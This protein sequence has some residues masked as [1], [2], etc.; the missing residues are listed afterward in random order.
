MKASEAKRISLENYIYPSLVDICV[1]IKEQAK[2]GKL[3]LQLERLKNSEKIHLEELGYT[4]EKK[5]PL[6]Q[7]KEVFIISWEV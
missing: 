6:Y 4:V 5:R 2:K 3:S 7:D 1:K